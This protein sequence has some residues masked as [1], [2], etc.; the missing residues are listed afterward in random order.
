MAPL[1]DLLLASARL[2]GLFF[3]APL[4]PGVAW[5]VR[6]AIPAAF[7]LAMP[8]GWSASPRGPTFDAPLLWTAAFAGEIV[9]GFA[10]GWGILLVFGAIRAAGSLVADQM[11]LAMGGAASTAPSDEGPALGSFY[12]VVAIAA[13][14]SLDAHALVLRLAAE[15]FRVAPPGAMGL[16]DVM[17]FPVR[18]VT[19][20]GPLLFEG[21]CVFGFPVLSVLILA[22][23]AQ[24][25]LSRV[26][27]EADFFSFGPALRAA[28][29]IGVAFASLPF[30]AQAARELFGAGVLSSMSLE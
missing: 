14:V 26:L 17:R 18:L 8:I 27:P 22:A 25:I 11:G 12:S 29:G 15:S 21:A 23:L 16:D 13:L 4:L 9:L 30:F 28:I 10:M 19:G 24:A 5:R 1:P 2:A 3:A 7:A 6:I 20:A